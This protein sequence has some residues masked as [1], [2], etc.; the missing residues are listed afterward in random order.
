MYGFAFIDIWY[1][2]YI[3]EKNLNMFNKCNFNVL[4]KTDC[5]LILDVEHSPKL[6][7]SNLLEIYCIIINCL[8]KAE[9]I[10]R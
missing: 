4:S 1:K 6:I 8:N 10:K 9:D 5:A 7:T 2:N 3:H